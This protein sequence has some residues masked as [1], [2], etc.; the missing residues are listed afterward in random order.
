VRLGRRRGAA[1]RRERRLPPPRAPRRLED[2]DPVRADGGRGGR[3]PAV[4]APDV[5]RP[6][7]R[8]E[9]PPRGLGASRGDYP[10]AMSAEVVVGLALLGFAV[11][12]IGTLVGAGGGFLLAPVLL[13]VYPHDSPQTLT[14]ISLAAVWANSTSGTIAYLRQHR[15]DIESG[16]VFG[17][18]TLP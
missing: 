18:A 4:D 3:V 8:E 9:R 7:G 17:V 6:P 12:V 16:L 2:D 10:R 1:E 13:I 15:V 14:S 11:G 5:P